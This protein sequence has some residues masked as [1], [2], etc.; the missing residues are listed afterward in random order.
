MGVVESTRGH[1]DG[2]V[3]HRIAGE[4]DGL[5]SRSDRDYLASSGE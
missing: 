4:W 1:D 3:Y 5:L 2:A